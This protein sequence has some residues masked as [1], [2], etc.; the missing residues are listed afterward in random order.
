[1]ANYPSTQAGDG[2]SAIEGAHK[3]LTRIS[4]LSG[5]I[6]PSVQNIVQVVV[7]GSPDEINALLPHQLQGVVH[8]AS[9]C[10]NAASECERF[11]VNV[12]GLAQVSSFRKI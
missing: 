4:Q 10:Q 8:L 6:A 12:S 1:M 7:Q 2:Y 5:Q 3:D 9:S 11:F